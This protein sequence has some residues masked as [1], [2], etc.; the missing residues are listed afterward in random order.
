M[1]KITLFIVSLLFLFGC[2]S[3]AS[4]T[5][6]T[7]TDLITTYTGSAQLQGWLIYKPYYSEDTKQPHFRI[8]DESLSSLPKEILVKIPQKPYLRDFAIMTHIGDKTVLASEEIIS[9]L[10]KY[11]E[12]NN[13]AIIVDEISVP[14]EGSPFLILAETKN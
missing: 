11:N 4:W 13:G 3:Q 1:K 10:K 2:A 5:T 6:E 8:A 7:E 12:N 14:S 9:D